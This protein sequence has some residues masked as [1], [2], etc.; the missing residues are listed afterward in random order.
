MDGSLI[1]AAAEVY[2]PGSGSC[3]CAHGA[4]VGGE[5]ADPGLFVDRD[6]IGEYECTVEFFLAGVQFLGVFDQGNGTGDALVSAA[7]IDDHGKFAAVHPCIGSGSGF[8][9][10][11]DCDVV[12][13]GMEENAPDICSVVAKEPLL[14]D[15]VVIADLAVQK[16]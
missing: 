1:I 9:F 11:P 14:G 7:G 16:L 12:S 15:G 3:A 8:C 13:V 6:Q 2:D 10:R 5:G 4:A